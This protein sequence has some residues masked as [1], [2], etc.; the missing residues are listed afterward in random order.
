MNKDR[1]DPPWMERFSTLSILR[2]DSERLEKLAQP[3]INRKNREQKLEYKYEVIN[4]ALDLLE[5]QQNK[6]QE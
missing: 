4:R 5:K 6:T 3:R 1:Y 2:S